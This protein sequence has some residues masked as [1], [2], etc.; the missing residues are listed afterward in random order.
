MSAHINDLSFDILKYIFSFL[1]DKQQFII[2]VVCSKWQK[3]VL[4]LLQEKTT[5]KRLNYYS[6]KF[7]CEPDHP[8]INRGLR[9]IDDSNIDILK[10]ILYKCNKI[11]HLELFRTKVTG[12][13]LI[14]IAKLCPKLES[15]S[16]KYS[17]IVASEDELDEFGKI[18]GPQLV[19]CNFR[20]FDTDF[21]MILFKHFK[22]LENVSFNSR[23]I[24]QNQTIFHHLNTECNKLKVLHW[25]CAMKN[26]QNEHLINVHQRIDHLI[27][28]LPIFSRLK[29]QLNNL[30]ELTL[31]HF[32]DDDIMKVEKT[33]PNLIKL[34]VSNF[35]DLDFDAISKFNFPKLESA[36]IDNYHTK[37]PLSFLEQ[38]QHIK[39]LECLYIETT[40]ASS[41]TRIIKQLTN[42]SWKLY[43]VTFENENEDDDEN[44]NENE[45][46]KLY[47]CFDTLSKH[48]MLDNIKF[49]INDYYMLIKNG[50]YEKLIIFYHSKPNTKIVINI[51]KNSFKFHEHSNDYK[52]LFYEM[53]YLH[54]LNIELL[55]Y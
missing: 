10:K 26:F 33:F 19:E 55:L 3:C 21:M 20:H 53:K 48:K 46:E 54:K 6:K 23:T 27:I 47:Q 44:E 41:I 11:K 39:S 25:R 31:Y 45:N 42:L 15:I 29:F 4:R 17:R 14:E 24:Q 52:E 38:I 40:F 35:K 28:S 34:N 5:L 18:I 9:K 37:V 50:F 16:F 49:E 22:N 2:E 7:I 51:D 30:T 43:Y 12:N 36:S 13:N 1:D 8:W 32:T